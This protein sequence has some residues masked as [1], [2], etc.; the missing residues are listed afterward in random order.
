[1]VKGIVLEKNLSSKNMQ[2]H[3]SQPKVLI[4]E[5]SIDLDSLASFI[6]F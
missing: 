4:I 1:M 6:K 3:L 2:T 5:N